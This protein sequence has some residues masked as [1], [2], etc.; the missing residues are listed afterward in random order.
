MLGQPKGTF[1]EDNMGKVLK[2]IIKIRLEGNA[3]FNFVENP[4]GYIYGMLACNTIL[5]IHGEEKNMEKTL[6]DFSAIY[7]VPIQYL[8]AGHLHHA[9]MEEI[10]MSSEV[11]NVP[12]IMGCDPYALSLHKVSDPAAKLLVFDQNYGK[13]CEYTIKLN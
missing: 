6:K 2:E 7:N 13:T 3:N 1:T 9:K 11:I 5:G 8:L 10:G 4:T 12:S